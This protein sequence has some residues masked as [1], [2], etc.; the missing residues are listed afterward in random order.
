MRTKVTNFQVGDHLPFTSFLLKFISFLVITI[1]P[2]M[3]LASCKSP[4]DSIYEGHFI[5]AF[6]VSAFFPCGTENV[7]GAGYWDFAY[8]LTSTPESGFSEQ[9]A[10]FISQSESK[11]EYNLYV[12]VVGKTSPT[13]KNGYGHLGMYSNQ[14]TVKEVLEMKPWDDSHCQ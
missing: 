14:I 11:W 7:D 1:M 5:S 4:Q 13:K 2:A 12:K 10:T 6:E 8:W 3:L 9:L